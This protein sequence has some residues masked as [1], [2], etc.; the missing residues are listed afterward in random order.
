[1][2]LHSVLIA[3]MLF[4][5]IMSRHENQL[6]N[7]IISRTV[8]DSM[9]QQQKALALLNKTHE[10][11]KACANFF[12]VMPG[13]VCASAFLYQRICTLWMV[14]VPAGVMRAY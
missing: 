7:S 14:K 1:M 5:L 6:L 2:F 12:Q 9:N 8:T 10:L 11:F 13:L 4:C 3:S